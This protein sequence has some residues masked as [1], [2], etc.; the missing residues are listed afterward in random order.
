MYAPLYDNNQ[1]RAGVGVAIIYLAIAIFDTNKYQALSL[2]FLSVLTHYSMILLV[3]P[4]GVWLIFFSAKLSLTQK[5]LLLI[6]V[7][8]AIYFQYEFIIYKLFPTA[9]LLADE[10]ETGS[11]RIFGANFVFTAI[12]IFITAIY[13]TTN[14]KLY[15]I[16]LILGVLEYFILI[17]QQLPYQ[18]RVLET[19]S[20]IIPIVYANIYS[21][22]IAARKA[23]I[24]AMTLMAI[25]APFYWI[26]LVSS[27]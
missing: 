6:S 25:Y 11:K 15:L 8:L 10:Q 26:S 2:L 27:A 3:A 16:I 21:K 9:V 20:S 18:Y 4:I 17:Y 19:A 13:S 7:S 14:K 24:G 12:C 5:S 22:N 1:I 23:I